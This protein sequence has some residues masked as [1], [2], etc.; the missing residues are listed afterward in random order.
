LSV[1]GG[2]E[3]GPLSGLTEAGR[4]AG[5]LTL[6]WAAARQFSPR[7][8]GRFPLGQASQAHALLASRTVSGKLLLQA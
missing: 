5:T 2:E 6:R 4:G 7:I 8:T 1:A 3:R